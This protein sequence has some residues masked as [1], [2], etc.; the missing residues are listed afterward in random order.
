[1]WLLSPGE[2][3]LLVSC[4]EG[5]LLVSCVEGRLLVSRVD[6]RLLLFGVDVEGRLLLSGV[7]GL[8]LLSGV[9]VAGRLLVRKSFAIIYGSRSLGTRISNSSGAITRCQRAVN[10]IK[11]SLIKTLSL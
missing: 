3:S 5:S 8:L 9:H 1:M 10:A 7:K 4:V 11:I 2:G 6:G